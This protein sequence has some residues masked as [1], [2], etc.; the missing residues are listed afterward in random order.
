MVAF[1]LTLV[2]L[3]NCLDEYV[4]SSHDALAGSYN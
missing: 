3:D 2:F 4:F 1:E